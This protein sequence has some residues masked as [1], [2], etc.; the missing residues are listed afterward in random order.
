MTTFK[1][2]QIKLKSAEL[3]VIDKMNF[4]EASKE[5]QEKINC[6]NSHATKKTYCK[7]FEDQ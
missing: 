3:H 2:G 7:F 1:A 6:S 4:R 5:I